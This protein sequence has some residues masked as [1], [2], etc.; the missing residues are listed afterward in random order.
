MTNEDQQQIRAILR[1]EMVTIHEEVAA[2]RQEIVAAEERSRETA[3]AMQTE[4]LR[5]LESFARGNFARFHRIETSDT[6]T[7]ARITAL[8]ERVLYLETRRPL[9]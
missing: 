5:G 4:I 1:E 9:H 3:R 6:D 7:N 2:V 8:E